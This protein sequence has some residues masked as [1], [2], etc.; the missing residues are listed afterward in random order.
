MK[1]R[2]AKSAT[3]IGD[4]T[5]FRAQTLAQLAAQHDEITRIHRQAD[6]TI[7]YLPNRTPTIGSCS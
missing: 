3:A 1:Q 6:Q 5:D 7:R 4:L 2:L